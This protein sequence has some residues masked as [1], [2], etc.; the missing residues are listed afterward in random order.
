MRNYNS[1]SNSNN[2]LDI[3]RIRRRADIATVVGHYVT[4]SRQGRSLTGLCPFHDD[5]H[6]SLMVSP[7]KGVFHCFSCGAG[8]D[9]FDF[10]KQ[11]EHCGFAEAARIVAS[12]CNVPLYNDVPPAAR[13]RGTAPIARQSGT[14]PVTRSNAAH[15]RIPGGLPNPPS[16]ERMNGGQA[17]YCKQANG[18]QAM[19]GQREMGEQLAD[20]ERTAGGQMAAYNEAFARTLIPYEPEEEALRETYRRFGVGLAPADGV[21][22]GYAFTRGRLV[23]PIVDHD[24]RMAGFAARSLTPAAN[25]VGAPNASAGNNASSVCVGN[26]ADAPANASCT[27]NALKGNT[28]SGNANDSQRREPKYINS[29]A[30]PLYQKGRILYGFFQAQ[31]RMAATNEVYLVEGYKDCLAMH[32]AGFTNTVAICGTSLTDDHIAALR[33][34]VSRVFMML[35]T[36]DAGRTVTARLIPRLHAAGLETRDIMPN[37]D[38]ISDIA[39][40]DSESSAYDSA[41]GNSQIKDPDEMFRFLGRDIFAAEIRTRSVDPERQHIE[42]LLL[43]ACLLWPETQCVVRDKINKRLVK[44][45]SEE[46]KATGRTLFDKPADKVIDKLQKE[47]THHDPAGSSAPSDAPTDSPAYNT[48]AAD[49]SAPS[50]TPAHNNTPAHDDTSTTSPTSSPAHNAAAADNTH[51]TDATPH[52]DTP[53][54]SP[55]SSPVHNAAVADNE[56]DLPFDA[57]SLVLEF[58]DELQRI[59]EFFSDNTLPEAVRRSRI[60]VILLYTY[61]EPLVAIDLLTAISASTIADLDE[62]TKGN[63]AIANN[64][65]TKGNE[66]IANNESTNHSETDANNET[67]KGNETIA[68]NEATNHSE[69]NANNEAIKGNEA[70]AAD[71]RPANNDAGM[72]MEEKPQYSYNARPVGNDAD[73]TDKYQTIQQLLIYLR[74]ITDYLRRTA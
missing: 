38:N 7:E 51:H 24:G 34:V 36:D 46:L 62:A 61:L 11:F 2:H 37:T 4:L 58:G 40:I 3:E 27:P 1:N 10:V 35:D 55:T 9:M 45:I 44:A 6:P 22:P 17:A 33:S 74:D 70:I 64:E 71:A 52:N 20:S 63:E 48:A 25:A 39:N 65:A 54:T 16:A 47:Y 73:R 41:I 14:A 53:T 28:S 50:D 18:G 66:T 23:F 15:D 49:N 72:S 12:R 43:A 26:A 57:E 32:A 31:Q 5:H 21:P 60:M 42:K 69:T 29:P 8:G 19:N 68:N 13:Q 67:T 56:L 59:Y 30:C